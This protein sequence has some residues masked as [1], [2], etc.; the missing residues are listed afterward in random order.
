MVS[1]VTGLHETEFK[2][3]IQTFTSCSHETW[4][5]LA[6]KPMSS[7]NTSPP[8]M[9]RKEVTWPCAK[10]QNKQQTNKISVN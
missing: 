4:K 6:I 9:T 7:G 5:T 8:M 1:L 2:M 10:K 3:L